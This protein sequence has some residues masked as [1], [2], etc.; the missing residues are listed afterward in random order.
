MPVSRRHLLSLGATGSVA[1]LLWRGAPGQAEEAMRLL[2]VPVADAR[3]DGPQ[4]TMFAGGCFWGIQGVFQHV[5]GVTQAVSG[6]AG[7]IV[8]NPDY[9]SV[10]TGRTGHA[11]VVR[12]TYDPKEVSYGTLLRIFFSVGLDPTQVNRQGPD[13]GTQYRS[14]LFV[15]DATQEG[16]A[17][18]YI[19][20]LDAARTYR[21][22]IATQVAAGQKFWPAEDYHQDYLALHPNQPYI[23]I[24]DI[25]KVQALERLFPE[26]WRARAVLVRAAGG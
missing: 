16:V 20:Q 2:P 12:V 14:A 17:R 15:A 19:A 24:H 26:N 5:R 3:A 11:E 7:G 23:A 22:P 6:Y 13:I 25:P 1:A 10:G 21:K 9:D 8:D 18:A 4:T